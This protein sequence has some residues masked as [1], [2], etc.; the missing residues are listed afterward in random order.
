MESS[1]HLAEKP[2]VWL[3]RTDA[4]DTLAAEVA[5]DLRPWPRVAASLLYHMRVCTELRNFNSADKDKKEEAQPH[6]KLW[7]NR[8]SALLMERDVSEA[9]A[10]KRIEEAYFEC[11]EKC[12][13]THGSREA[14][15]VGVASRLKCRLHHCDPLAE[16]AREFLRNG[17]PCIWHE[18]E[19]SDVRRK[20]PFPLEF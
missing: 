8:D 18:G 15:S 6:N 3:Q 14:E 9:K 2:K 5:E 20:F 12:S 4:P 17:I 11:L 13:A 1:L 16:R 10:S 19:Y 7:V